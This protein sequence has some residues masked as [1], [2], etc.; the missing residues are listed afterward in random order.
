MAGANAKCTGVLM[1][2]VDIFGPAQLGPDKLAARPR[3][4]RINLE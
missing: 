1:L 4:V 2:S 3:Q